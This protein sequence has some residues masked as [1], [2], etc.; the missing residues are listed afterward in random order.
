MTLRFHITS[1]RMVKFKISGDS[2]CWR[3]CGERNTPPLLVRLQAVT[4]IWKSVLWLLSK[5]DLVLPEDP[6]IPLLSIYPEYAPTCNKDTCSTMFIAALVV[7]AQSWKGSRCPS[8]EDWIQKM[9]WST[10]QL[11]KRMK[12]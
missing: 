1:V 8:T 9:C 6:V 11:L 4:T 3:G 10:N 12:S 2:R 5:L 7:I